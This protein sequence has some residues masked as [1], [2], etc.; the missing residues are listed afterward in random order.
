MRMTRRLRLLILTGA[1]MSLLG[2]CA[3]IKIPDF[4]FIN[5]PDFKDDAENVGEYLAVADAPGAPTD[6]RSG[7]AWDRSAKELIAKRDGFAVPVSG[8][9]PMTDAQIFA[10][11]KRLAAK[12][13]AYKLD[14]PQ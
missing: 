3:S 8:E 6:I 13:S 12:V 4:D 14:D 10:E 1:S 2:G 9:P 11:M 7:A 5:L